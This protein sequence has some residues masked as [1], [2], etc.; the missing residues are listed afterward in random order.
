MEK[1]P[2]VF[3]SLVTSMVRVGEESGNLSESLRV[4]GVQL[5]N[6]YA[7]HKKV[8]GAMMYPS[9]VI[10]AMIIIGILMFIYV[11]PTLT[12]TFKDFESELPKSTQLIIFISD[13]LAAH[14][15]LTFLFIFGAVTVLVLIVF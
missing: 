12:A 5:G 3:S 1:F 4:I 15:L 8:K 10:S 9:I 7:L 6:S 14:T 13:S 11:V 2:K